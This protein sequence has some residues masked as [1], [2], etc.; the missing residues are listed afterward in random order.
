MTT[1]FLRHKGAEE[2]EVDWRPIE[3]IPEDYYT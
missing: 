2:G 3:T 1:T